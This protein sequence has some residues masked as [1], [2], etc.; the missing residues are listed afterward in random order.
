MSFFGHLLL[1]LVYGL[2]AAA[3]AVA[4]PYAGEGM[5]P[6]TAMWIG[7]GIFVGGFILHVTASRLGWAAAIR[8]EINQLSSDRDRLFA[9][10]FETREQVRAIEDRLAEQPSAANTR[11]VVRDEVKMLHG[12]LEQIAQHLS[13]GATGSPSDTP[14][15]APAHPAA[16]PAAGRKGDG[17][18]VRANLRA[19][20]EP[21]PDKLSDEEILALLDDAI[22]RDRIDIALSPIVTLPQRKTRHFEAFSRIMTTTGHYL[23]PDQYQAIAEREGLIVP[24]DNLLLF[25]CIQLIRE[26]LRQHNRRTVFANMSTYSLGDADFMRQLFE[27]LNANTALAPHLVLEFRM[28]DLRA[29]LRDLRPQMDRM[30]R[31]G[32]RFSIDEAH[33]L[34]RLDAEVLASAHIRFVKINAATLLK[35]QAAIPPLDVTAAK[36]DLDRSAIDLIVE[37]IADEETLRELV[38]LPIDYG[39]GP[40]FRDTSLRP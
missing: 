32:F 3:A 28:D 24:V 20:P 15:A 26:S 27:F 21:S 31:L 30:A 17:A 11:E 25:R 40:L 13:T 7:G 18:E 22:K 23:L 9:E 39:E 33:D 36:R 4:L 29:A 12:L 16:A 14:A 10:L 5:A 38:G 37:G 8:R 35:E 34:A 1:M 6:R 2:I 19:P